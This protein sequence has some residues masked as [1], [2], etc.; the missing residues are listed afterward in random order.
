MDK[1]TS[2]RREFIKDALLKTNSI[3]FALHGFK[4]SI[5]DSSNFDSGSHITSSGIVYQNDFTSNLNGIS[6]YAVL[7]L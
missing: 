6:R 4:E 1:N 3:I 5:L 7:N 2:K